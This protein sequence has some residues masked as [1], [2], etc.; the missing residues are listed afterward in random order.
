MFG[1]QD[2]PQSVSVE[3]AREGGKRRKVLKNREQRVEW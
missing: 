1:R 2:V 3:H